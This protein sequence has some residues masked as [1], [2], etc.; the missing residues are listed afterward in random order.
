[1]SPLLFSIYVSDLGAE[2][3]RSG[4]GVQ[5]DETTNISAVF[6]ADDIALISESEEKLDQLL[7]IVTDWTV[8]WKMDISVS[9][10]KVMS[11]S[12]DKE[13][14]KVFNT[15][16]N[17]WDSMEV[18]QI[19]KY[20]GAKIEIGPWRMF[21]EFN[22]NLISTAKNYMYHILSLSKMGPDTSEVACALW[23]QCAVPAILYGTEVMH[24]SETSIMELERI[25]S[26]VANFILQIPL[27]SSSTAG[28]VDVGFKSFRQLIHERKIVYHK[29]LLSLPSHCWARVAYKVLSKL[30]QKSVYIRD[31]TNIRMEYDILTSSKKSALR[32]IGVKSDQRVLEKC[33]RNKKSMILMY[34]TKI[35]HAKK[36]WVNDSNLSGLLCKFRASDV[37]LGN[38]AP[39]ENRIQYKLCKLCMDRNGSR[40][41]NNEVHLLMSCPVLSEARVKCGISEFINRHSRVGARKSEVT[42]ARMYLGADGSDHD[43]EVLLDRAKSLRIM[44]DEWELKMKMPA[45]SSLR[46]SNSKNIA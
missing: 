27:R 1:M 35:I 13:S 46:L 41:L 19:F 16:E 34:P 25:Q 12:S 32:K 18:V 31:V 3:N 20:L 33:F 37:G 45:N 22:F 40:A 9:K 30:G 28:I 43:S 17:K 11:M 24:V 10:S 6:F 5:L 44:L 14:W 8:K 36:P 39:L 15:E 26:K 23:S 2:L 38:R 42:L 4:L 21:K 29:R 7:K